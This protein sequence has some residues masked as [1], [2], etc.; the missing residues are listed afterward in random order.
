M[1]TLDTPPYAK[2]EE[3]KGQRNKGTITSGMS[4]SSSTCPLG[5]PPTPP[6][7][8]RRQII[9]ANNRHPRLWTRDQA[10]IRT[11]TIYRHLASL[12]RP[13]ENQLT[14]QTRERATRCQELRSVSYSQENSKSDR[15]CNNTAKTNAHLHLPFRNTE[16]EHA[17]RKWRQAKSFSD[18]HPSRTLRSSI[19]THAGTL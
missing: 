7:L 6:S 8:C 4:S 13:K 17:H 1:I 15:N 18:C 5:Q 16:K 12:R 10:T 3:A 9:P 2:T 11:R 14:N 19:A